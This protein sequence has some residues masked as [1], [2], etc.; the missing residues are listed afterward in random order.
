MYY[1]VENEI[2]ELDDCLE[3]RAI[4]VYLTARD[5]MSFSFNVSLNCC[6]LLLR[7]PLKSVMTGTTDSL[8]C[9]PGVKI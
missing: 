6:L 1:E 2:G 3:F 7:L 9:I 8:W 5:H 4:G